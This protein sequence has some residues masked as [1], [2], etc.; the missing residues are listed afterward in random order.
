MDIIEEVAYQ[1]DSMTDERIN[2]LKVTYTN[3]KLSAVPMDEEN[4][5]YRD[6]LKWVENGGV[7]DE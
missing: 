1:Y 4:K 5:Q 3:G 2:E 7:I 6:V